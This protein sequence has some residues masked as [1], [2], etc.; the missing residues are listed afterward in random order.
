MRV[1]RLAAA[2]LAGAIVGVAAAYLFLQPGLE[3]PAQ[4]DA[5]AAP[6]TLPDG[7]PPRSPAASTVEPGPLPTS[8]RFAVY[9]YAAKSTEPDE[10]ESL[11]HSTA[12]LA[13]SHRR[14]F[15]LD[16]L[17][18]RLAE[19]DVARAVR[20]ARTLRLPTEHLVPLFQLWA[21][22]DAGEALAALRDI[23]NPATVR[24]IA[25]ALIDVLGGDE[26]ALE[27]IAA[28]LSPAQ[29]PAFRLEALVRL[30]ET[31]PFRALQG[32]LALSE[33]ST[34]SYALNRIATEWARRDP[35][36]ALA[37]VD[38]IADDAL[39][40]SYQFLVLGEWAR[41]DP[42][43]V[44]EHIRSL[45]GVGDRD[46]PSF[47]SVLSALAPADPYAVLELA[48][49]LPGNVRGTAQQVAIGVIAARDPYEAIAKVESMPR[50]RDRERLLAAVAQAFGERDPD[51]ALEWAKSLRPAQPNVLMSLVNGIA[52]VD[53]ERAM[54]LALGGDLGPLSSSALPLMIATTTLA[55][56]QDSTRIAA[57]ADRLVASND[58]NA[59]N[60]I[61]TLMSAWSRRDP[62]AAVEWLIQN[63]DRAGR[64]AIVQV[65]SQL[66]AEDPMAAAG[67]IGRLPPD[68]QGDWLQSV[69]AGYAQYD[70][71]GAAA[72][73]MQYQGRP[74]F[75]QGLAAIAPALA[76]VDAPTA[77]GM[78]E[79]A[80]GSV[81]SFAAGQVASIWAIRDPIAA[82]D[83]A[84]QLDDAAARSNA[85][86]NVVS[87]WASQDP[88]GARRWVLG[89]PRGEL[90]DQA[91]QRLLPVAT[92]SG[93]EIDRQLL[94]AFS[95]DMHRQTAVMNA[96]MMLGNRDRDAARRL[97]DQYVTDAQIRQ[98]AYTMIEQRANMA[99][100]APG[101]ILR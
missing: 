68:L 69:A 23:D 85:I 90:R 9:A 55:G 44:F 80:D 95:N 29:V 37:Q 36:A 61:G 79:R 24:E 98:Q 25:L 22:Q 3:N 19:L 47:V 88:D 57:I 34:R 7:A 12:A 6:A 5:G 31:D 27:R 42:E 93:G 97:V 72:W 16:A 13:P 41:F 11:I 92:A 8:D 10:L 30:A 14:T 86:S 54:D 73:I 71:E 48:E 101:I 81:A 51:G 65:A 63:A 89:Q 45:R 66:A 56:L 100:M 67:M 84:M 74:G 20:F 76:Q 52:S 2:A 87:N 17:L 75:S 46:L 50:H 1:A 35:A 58:V 26:R 53:P 82:A 4:D 18:V 70:A 32:A 77:A 59:L 94:D 83:W 49:E 43:G 64:Q 96:A 28:V 40:R 91:L 60:R 78:L 21:E 62:E 39:R 38:T 15:E 33:S 99:V